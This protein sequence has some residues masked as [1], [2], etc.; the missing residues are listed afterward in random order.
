MSPMPGEGRQAH[1]IPC[2]LSLRPRC[3]SCSDSGRLAPVAIV[4]L[5]PLL[6]GSYKHVPPARGASPNHPAP[7]CGLLTVVLPTPWL[8][9]SPPH[10]T[11]KVSLPPC[12]PQSGS[13]RG[14]S[15]GFVLSPV[16][17][18]DVGWVLHVP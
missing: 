16:T 18:P 1:S 15:V 9:L 4:E 14:G 10:W 11:V 6:S 2:L 8:Y 12:G 13:F 17:V 7:N 3:V 5:V